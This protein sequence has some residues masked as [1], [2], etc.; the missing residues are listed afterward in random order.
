MLVSEGNWQSYF[1]QCGDFHIR[2]NLAKQV[3]KE[4]Q[5]GWV[6]LKGITDPVH[7]QCIEKRAPF[8]IMAEKY[9]EDGTKYR[10]VFF[11]K[12]VFGSLITQDCFKKGGDGYIE[13]PSRF[14]PLL[15]GGDKDKLQSYNPIYK[16]NIYGLIKNTHKKSHIEIPRQELIRNIAP[17][18]LDSQGDLKK[19]TAA[20]LHDSLIKNTKDVLKII[21]Y[22]L[23][24]KNFYL[25]KQG[26][27][28]TIYFRTEE[29]QE[30]TD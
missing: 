12:V 4:L 29:Q 8:R 22:S 19:I 28:S 9:F 1:S 23:L 17:E 24:V 10:E 7:G 25:G 20:V 14:Y 11:A 16:L 13:I 5:T 18:Y 6:K 2:Y 26:G 3:M 15:T 21:P 27:S 30:K